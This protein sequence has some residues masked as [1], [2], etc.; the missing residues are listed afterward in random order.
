LSR[1]ACQ[2]M[3]V[4]LPDN[5]TCGGLCQTFPSCLPPISAE[6]LDRIVRDRLLGGLEAEAIGRTADALEQLRAAIVRGLA[7]KDADPRPH[8]QLGS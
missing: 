1:Q 2:H 5:S 8:R 4:K 3:K 7:K 6:V